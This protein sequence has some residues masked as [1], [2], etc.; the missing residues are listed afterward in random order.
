MGIFRFF[1]LNVPVVMSSLADCLRWGSSRR[2]HA[3]PGAIGHALG[4]AAA[5]ALVARDRLPQRTG[6]S[7]R[8]VLVDLC[9]LE[10]TVNNY[11]R[12]RLESKNAASS[13]DA[14]SSRAPKVVQRTGTPPGK[15]KEL[16]AACAAFV[17]LLGKYICEGC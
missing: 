1:F 12:R 8:L 9:E 11:T 2:R 7:I 3:R 17:A 10:K 6:F 13:T 5:D 14:T 4:W 15:P 16:P